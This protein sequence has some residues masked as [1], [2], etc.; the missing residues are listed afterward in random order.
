MED[1]CTKAQCR[2][3]LIQGQAKDALIWGAY[4]SLKVIDD[5]FIDAVIWDES[6]VS[7]F[8]TDLKA[9]FTFQQAAAILRRVYDPDRDDPA[10]YFLLMKTYEHVRLRT[11]KLKELYGIDMDFSQF[12]RLMYLLKEYDAVVEGSVT[13]KKYYVLN[14]KLERLF[15]H[16]KKNL[17]GSLEYLPRVVKMDFAEIHDTKIVFN[18]RTEVTKVFVMNP[19]RRFTKSELIKEIMRNSEAKARAQEYYQAS[20]DDFLCAKM[21]LAIGTVLNR[22]KKEGAAI[23]LKSG[24][25]LSYQYSEPLEEITWAQ[26]LKVDEDVIQNLQSAFKT[27]NS[28]DFC[29]AMPTLRQSVEKALRHLADAQKIA[30]SDKPSR[31][32]LGPINERLFAEHIYDQSIKTMVDAFAMEVNPIIHGAIELKNIERTKNLFE[33]AQLIIQEIYQIKRSKKKNV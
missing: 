2:P 12:E 25:R 22:M 3:R 20:I 10:I 4:N 8:K 24:N 6:L 9:T 29:G 7:R 19:G 5:K 14:E 27:F 16:I 15:S 21:R 13:G 31:D 30:L 23:E 28:G 17:G 18:L 11:G 32:T 26:S 1:I 33:R